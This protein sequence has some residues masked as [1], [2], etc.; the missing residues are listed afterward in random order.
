MKNKTPK[1]KIPA[2]NVKYLCA[3]GGRTAAID[4]KAG[5]AR[6]AGPTAVDL[7]PAARSTA[8]EALILSFNYYII[9]MREAHTA[10]PHFSLL[11]PIF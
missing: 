4:L 9:I 2:G 10:T 8:A 3:P 11:T 5:S 1:V 6:S 7:K